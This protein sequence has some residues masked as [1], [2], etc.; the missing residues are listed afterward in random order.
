M[1]YDPKFLTSD[2][3]ITEG[4]ALKLHGAGTLSRVKIN[5]EPGQ[6]FI[7]HFSLCI[8]ILPLEGHWGECKPIPASPKM[9]QK[10]NPQEHWK[11]IHYHQL[12]SAE[13]HSRCVVLIGKSGAGKSTIANQLVQH[14]PPIKLPAM[15]EVEFQW[16][17][18]HYRLL[19][20][21]TVGFLPTKEAIDYAFDKIEEYIITNI[22]KINLFLF[23]IKK[24]CFTVEDQ[25]MF[26]SIFSLIGKRLC[27]DFSPISA[28]AITGC[29]N[30][31]SGIR[32]SRIREFKRNHSTQDIASQ[33]GMGIYAVGFPDVKVLHPELQQHYKKDM[34]EDRD[35]LRAL[36]VQA[37]PERDVKVMMAQRTTAET[38]LCDM[39]PTMAQ[40]TRLNTA[41]GDLEI[42]ETIAPDW[43]A[44]GCLMDFD[45]FGNKL[46]LIE[47]EH[48]HKRNGVLTCCQ[49]I[50][51]LWLRREDATWEKLIQ[52]IPSQHK[53]LAKQVM[54]AVGL[55]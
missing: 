14:E 26:T 38:R 21:D 6:Y 33:M 9:C 47:A 8:C 41:K 43:K 48:A 10:R 18:D 46:D 34:L 35:I 12:L 30:D 54:D 13:K 51:K 2:M 53:V 32:K 3:H 16:E 25:E 27:N 4:Y 11:L 28:L 36:I 5:K 23:V 20:I 52:L 40:L 39:K 29:E 50:F 55:S 42:I 24:G 1:K 19:V 45:P 15:H 37:K 44:V 49:E 31:T 7:L 17:N 22:E